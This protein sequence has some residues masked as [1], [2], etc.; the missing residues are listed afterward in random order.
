[1]TTNI[2]W[3]NYA[4]TQKQRLIKMNQKPCLLWFTGLSGSGKSTIA[5]AVEL[6]LFEMN[7]L[8]YLLD[9]DN[10][11]HGI[12]KDLGYSKNDRAENV[13]RIAEVSKLF[14]DAGLLILVASISPYEKDREKVKKIVK[15]G[16]FIEIFID[17][18]I[19]ICEKRDVKG[20]YSK[21]RSGEINNFTGIS[22]PYEKPKKPDIHIQTTQQ[23]IEDSVK[24]ICNFISNKGFINN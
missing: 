16:K 10:I 19:N 13:R 8:T 1:M 23:S 21:A 22:S 5:N 17:T 6:K 24:T 20:L 7:I 4:L 9:G 11:R 3:Q 2:F 12:N 14:L 18:P 15:K